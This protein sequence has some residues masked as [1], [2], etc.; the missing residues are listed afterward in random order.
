MKIK[1]AFWE[2][3]L[4]VL[5]FASSGIESCP[6]IFIPIAAIGALALWNLRDVEIECD[7]Y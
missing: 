4:V 2:C 7:E 6:I 1:E 5:L 3:V